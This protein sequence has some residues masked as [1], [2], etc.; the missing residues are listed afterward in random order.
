MRSGNVLISGAGIAGP[1]LAYW[2][3]RHGCT[4]TIVERATAPRHGGQA[5]DIRGTARDVVTRMGI[6]DQVRAC[7]TGT[8]GIAYVDARNRR[9][10]AM[11]GEDFGHSGGII[12][13]LEILRGDLVRILQDA[14]GDVEYLYG[15]TITGLAD[16]P[17]GVDVTFAHAAP[18][19]FD[20]VV[21]A[22]GLGSGVRRLAF[23]DDSAHVHD[24]GY[25]AA[26]YAARTDLALDG[27]ELLYSMP[28]GNGVRGRLVMLYPIGDTGEVRAMFAFAAPHAQHDREDPAAQ[29]ALLAQVFAG[30]GWQVPNLLRQLDSVDDLHF[31]RA[32]EVRLDRWSAGRSVL[33]GDAAFG[34]SVGMGTSMALVGAYVLAGEL[35][36]ADGDHT[37]AFA[38]YER[39]MREYVTASRTRP[40]G[41]VNGFLPATRTG[42]RLRT[43]VMRALPHLPGKEKMM[44]GI[45]TAASLIQLKDYDRTA[46]APLSTPE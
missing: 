38:A 23:G 33:L 32:G 43:L 27:W 45:D 35:A 15:D 46:A 34:G 9:L 12:A 42:I 29:R 6:M 4:P 13:E 16:G 5:V 2:L 18:R 25:Y 3:R 10:A 26:Y 22:D 39:E 20:V 30:E 44:G 7:H 19:R 24:L 17:D 41:G 37:V 36:A 1:A 28:A 31:T 8:H 14:A 21:G 40:P 11:R